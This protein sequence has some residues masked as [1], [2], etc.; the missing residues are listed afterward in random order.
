MPRLTVKRKYQ[1]FKKKLQKGGSGNNARS[2]LY[3]NA[4]DFLTTKELINAK[5][6]IIE[7]FSGKQDMFDM[8]KSLTDP[9]LELQEHDR[10]KKGPE[11]FWEWYKSK[12]PEFKPTGELGLTG[13]TGMIEY[14]T[15]LAQMI[16]DLC[17][18]L[19][20]RKYNL[21]NDISNINN[22]SSLYNK[23]L[24]SKTNF[25]EEHEGYKTMLA[26]KDIDVSIQNA[27]IKQLTEE[28]TEIEK[29]KQKWT[30]TNKNNE[31]KKLRRISRKAL[32]SRN[33]KDFTNEKLYALLNEINGLLATYN[34]EDIVK[35]I[36][37]FIAMLSHNIGLQVL[38]EEISQYL[39]NI[40]N[41]V[42]FIFPTYKQLQ[43]HRVVILVGV[44]I[45]NFRISNRKR[46][47]HE[48]YESPIVELAHDLDFHGRVSHHY[49]THI[50]KYNSKMKKYFEEMH[51]F[52]SALHD[53]YYLNEGKKNEDKLNIAKLLF[54]ILHEIYHSNYLA[55]LLKKPTEA[56]DDILSK[57]TEIKLTDDNKS[58]FIYR[59]NS[60]NLTEEQK[61][62]LCISGRD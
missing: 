23:E 14:K 18:M 37:K 36:L 39:S 8:D 28:K 2:N 54:I 20:T 33:I 29:E 45:I 35:V 56:L 16:R 61:N 55:K 24:K 50:A 11:F 52:I 62:I 48:D 10:F 53:L 38:E 58:R 5:G 19:M 49:N 59:L 9:F 13:L 47:I 3:T 26:T 6:L 31:N 41:S 34:Y 22:L 7:I 1:T 42:C 12:N 21:D 57:E 15:L 17:I 46:K 30:G 43:F 51:S 44:P 32:L 25:I 27:K 40:M 60:L 4:I